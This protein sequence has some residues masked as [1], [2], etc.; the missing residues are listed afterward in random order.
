MRAPL[1]FVRLCNWFSG[2]RHDYDGWLVR[3]RR[4]SDPDLAQRPD[5]GFVVEA[6][7]AVRS[8]RH[9]YAIDRGAPRSAPPDDLRIDR[10][11]E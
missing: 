5:V 10:R 1:H 9:A 2:W 3:A 7:I 6:A 11:R 8:P 4:L